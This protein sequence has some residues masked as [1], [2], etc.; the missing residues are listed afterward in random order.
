MLHCLVVCAA[1]QAGHNVAHTA[2]HVRHVL[3]IDAVAGLAVAP[4]EV[5][6]S[7]SVRPLHLDDKSI[8]EQHHLIVIQL[9]WVVWMLQCLAQVDKLGCSWQ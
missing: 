3:D 1:R 2:V 5:G 8:N 6:V 9:L 7:C 4:T